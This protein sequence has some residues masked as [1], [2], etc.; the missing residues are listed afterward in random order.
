MALHPQTL[1]QLTY[2][3]GDEAQAARDQAGALPLLGPL[4][5]DLTYGHGNGMWHERSS[6]K[7]SSTVMPM[8]LVFLVDR[9]GQT[10]GRDGA[11]K[12]VSGLSGKTGVGIR[13]QTGVG[14]RR[15]NLVS[16]DTSP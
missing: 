1:Q 16:G 10:S 2:G 14:I 8:P 4:D 15:Q 7:V 12:P 9:S 6:L 13:R 5:N 3:A 11:A